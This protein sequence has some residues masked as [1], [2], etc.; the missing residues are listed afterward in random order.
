[1]RFSRNSASRQRPA[2]FFVFWQ[3]PSGRHIEKTSVRFDPECGCEARSSRIY[4]GLSSW[5]MLC[6]VLGTE[7]YE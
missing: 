6:T 1:M 4:R 2:I 3:V 7:M 5:E